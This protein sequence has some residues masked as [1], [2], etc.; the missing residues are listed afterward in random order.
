MTLGLLY[1]NP[2]IVL[3][4]VSLEIH[5]YLL[6]TNRIFSRFMKIFHFSLNSLKFNEDTI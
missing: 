1:F 6:F 4:A 5:N 2:N 3:I